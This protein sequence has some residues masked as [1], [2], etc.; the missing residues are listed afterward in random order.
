MADKQIEFKWYQEREP[1]FAPIVATFE[2]APSRL[3]LLGLFSCASTKHFLDRMRKV[4]P[5]LG[6]ITSTKLIYFSDALESS[7]ESISALLSMRCEGSFRHTLAARK[8][9]ASGAQV[10]GF[11]DGE[12]ASAPN[13]GSD[14]L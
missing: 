7:L 8:M 4:K 1:G 5:D 3:K 11:F 12:T 14:S 10:S 9:R 13:E 2:A 6:M